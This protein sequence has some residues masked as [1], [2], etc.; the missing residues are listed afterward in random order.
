MIYI[1]PPLTITPDQLTTLCDA[2]LQVTAEWS[3]W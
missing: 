1:T 2:V 3:T